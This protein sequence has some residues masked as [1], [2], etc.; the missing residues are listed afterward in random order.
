MNAGI[1]QK[2]TSNEYISKDL[3]NDLFM[4][5]HINKYQKSQI[6][7]YIS[8]H[9]QTTAKIVEITQTERQQQHISRKQTEVKSYSRHVL[10]S[11]WKK[12]EGVVS[13]LELLESQQKKM[14]F[15]KENKTRYEAADEFGL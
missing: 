10:R 12:K 15:V 2:S 8:I 3:P 4:H 11:S 5:M 6:M 1:W 7:D 14:Q 9:H 13:C